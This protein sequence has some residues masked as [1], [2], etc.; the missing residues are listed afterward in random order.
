MDNP[1]WVMGKK[2]NGNNISQR[3]ECEYY[4]RAPAEV[5]AYIL[6]SL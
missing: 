6:S 2:M 1:E 5:P 4:K 3:F